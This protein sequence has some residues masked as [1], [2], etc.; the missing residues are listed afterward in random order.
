MAINL[1]LFLCSA[2]MVFST[3]KTGPKMS[4][5][6]PRANFTLYLRLAIIMG[7]TWIT[8]LVAG[9]VN[10]EPIW[11]V[12]VGLNALQGLFIF[13]SF[14]CNK[15]ILRGLGERWSTVSFSDPGSKLR[16]LQTTTSTTGGDSASRLVKA[17]KSNGSGKLM[18][19]EEDPSQL[20]AEDR[21]TYSMSK[22]EEANLSSFKQSLDG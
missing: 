16:T 10:L 8:A 12:F 3:T 4:T 5:C 1:F 15:K 9:F 7:L 2:Y 21:T 17:R 20:V 11:F 18:V 22:Y 6:G 14:T 13:V 19:D